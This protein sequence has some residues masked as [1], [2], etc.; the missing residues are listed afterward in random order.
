MNS[1][2]AGGLPPGQQQQ[3]TWP[4]TV[5]VKGVPVKAG[6]GSRQQLIS[7]P[8]TAPSIK[9]KGWGDG[10]VCGGG[11]EGGG[12]VGGGGR[13]G[14]EGRPALAAAAAHLQQ[15][16]PELP[17][18]A[19]VDDEVEGVVQEEEDGEEVVEGGEEPG[20][21]VQPVRHHPG[22]H[23]QHAQWRGE[24]HVHSHQRHQQLGQGRLLLHPAGDGDGRRVLDGRVAAGQGGPAGAKAQRQPRQQHHHVGQEEREGLDVPEVHGV[25]LG[26]G[27]RRR[28]HGGQGR[29][30][31]AQVEVQ[32]R[33]V[34]PEAGQGADQPHAEDH[35][36]HHGGLGGRAQDAGARR[37]H[38]ECAL[39]G[40]HDDEPDGGVPEPV[41]AAEGVGLR[42]DQL[43]VAAH[44]VLRGQE[45]GGGQEQ[46]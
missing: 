38:G 13:R 12:R 2:G 14:R 4:I 39:E 26:R 25:V 30:V 43:V 10:C 44:V 27:R 28:L 6:G 17:V 11:G 24:R 29:G 37:G 32:G 16:Q 33:V 23:L 42:D 20:V 9:E 19:E 8:V 35:Q 34:L 1:F 45:A 22:Q 36:H 40:H 18:V 46:Q 41:P 15:G 5:S 7:T 31:E 21:R 3:H